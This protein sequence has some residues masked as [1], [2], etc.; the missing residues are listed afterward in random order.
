MGQKVGAFWTYFRVYIKIEYNK[1]NNLYF[2]PMRQNVG[3]F[4]GK[5]K[6]A[7]WTYFRVY[8]KMEDN[9]LKNLFFSPMGQNSL[10]IYIPISVYPSRLQ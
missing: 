10:I 3:A 8:I 1:L 9:K 6:G 4:W 5:N 2:S 7:F